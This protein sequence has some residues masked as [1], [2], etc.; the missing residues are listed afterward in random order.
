MDRFQEILYNVAIKN[1]KDLKE[2][3]EYDDQLDV[4]Y[5]LSIFFNFFKDTIFRIRRGMQNFKLSCV[6]RKNSHSP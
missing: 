4:S 2:M 3:K 5:F 1:T 6:V